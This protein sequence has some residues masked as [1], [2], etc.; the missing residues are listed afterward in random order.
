MPAKL[1]IWLFRRAAGIDLPMPGLPENGIGLFLL[2]RGERARP[3]RQLP[4][5]EKNAARHRRMPPPSP[6]DRDNEIVRVG[7]GLDNGL[8]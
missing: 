2:L 1:L 5:L 3:W 4:V 7:S 6:S 8:A